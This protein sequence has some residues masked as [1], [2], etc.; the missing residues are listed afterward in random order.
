MNDIARRAGVAAST[1][2]RALREDPRL[3]PVTRQRIR[4]LADAM[5][6][7][8]EPAFD[9]LA[10]KRWG[11]APRAPSGNLAWLGFARGLPTDILAGIR[12]AAGRFAYPLEELAV[13]DYPDAAQ[14]DR[15]LQARG[16]RGI[17]LPA[18]R[19]ADPPLPALDWDRY[20]VVSCSVDFQHP[21]FHIVRPDVAAKVTGAWRECLDRGYRR[22]GVALPMDRPGELDIERIGAAMYLQQTARPETRRLPV[23]RGRFGDRKG[24]ARWLRRHRPDAVIGHASSLIARMAEA[25][26]RVPEDAGFAALYVPPGEQRSA[27]FD[28]QPA[29][30]G[31]EAVNLMDGMIRRNETGIPA[32][33]LTILIHPRWVEGSTLPA[34]PGTATRT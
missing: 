16:V 31:R 7:R 29:W 8:P 13:A 2:S 27:G 23:W 6:Y 28:S 14:L 24:F 11:L 25:G 18:L 21:P 3:P 33:P 19:H 20:A 30:L 9:I 32:H 1:V 4:D 22:I 17:F 5:G 15:V 34:R 12:L 10:R 26:I